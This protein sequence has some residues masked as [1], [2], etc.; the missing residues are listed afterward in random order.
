MMNIYEFITPSDA[1]TFKAENDKIAFAVTVIIGSGKAGCDNHNTGE[2][3]PTILI[4]SEDP[5]KDVN[6]F[7]G[8]NIKEFMQENK[9]RIKACLK[10][11]AYGSIEDRKTY[12]DALDSITD[13]EKLKE[14][15]AKHEDRNRTSMNQWVQAA[16]DY[17]DNLF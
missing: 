2:S 5:E 1:V 12:D 11:F 15:K 10:S 17:S 3:L 9:S 13:E 8:E 4:M 6:K 14:F 7:L 16:W